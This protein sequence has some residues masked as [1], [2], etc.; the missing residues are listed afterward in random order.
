MNVYNVV[1]VKRTWKIKRIDTP[2][3]AAFVVDQS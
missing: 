1:A 2:I 3:V